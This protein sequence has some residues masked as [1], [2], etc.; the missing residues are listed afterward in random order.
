ELDRL[1]VEEIAVNQAQREFLEE[2]GP[3]RAAVAELRARMRQ[4]GDRLVIGAPTAFQPRVHAAA[5]RD[6]V[7]VADLHGR[8]LAIDAVSGEVTWRQRTALRNV[9]GVSL[10][11]GRVAL[12]GVM[13]PGEDHEGHAALVLDAATGVVALGPLEFAEPIAE[14]RL[15]GDG[16]MVV[17]TSSEASWRS[18]DHGGLR[19]RTRLGVIEN[20]ASMHV[21]PQSVMLVVRRERTLMHTVIGLDLQSGTVLAGA[22]RVM[23]RPVVDRVEVPPRPMAHDSGW[24]VLGTPRVYGVDTG[25][26]LAWVDGG[27][28][29]LGGSV[30]AA[31]VGTNHAV[32]VYAEQRGLRGDVSTQRAVVFELATGRIVSDEAVPFPVGGALSGTAL[33]RRDALFLGVGDRTVILPLEEPLPVPPPAGLLEFP[34]PPSAAAPV[35]AGPILT[36]ATSP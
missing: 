5:G 20:V 6:A 13:F 16:G 22:E 11:G 31:Y 14:V 15:T 19:W 27:A 29:P 35:G 9:A 36:P 4:A 24:L 30:L 33:T 18:V 23:S 12:R 21:G 17:V 10:D 26:E 32:A 8:V 7:V 28:L 3:G 34:V 2:L 1:G 25:G